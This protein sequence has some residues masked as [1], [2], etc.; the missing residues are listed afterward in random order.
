M[1]VLVG[2]I[3]I[4]GIR[5]IANVT[6]KLVPFMVLLYVF[7]ALVVIAM[8]AAALPAAVSA[9]IDGAFTL[10]GAAG[11]FVGI[12]ILGFQR[13]AFSNE[14]GLGSAAIAH[15]AVM[16]DKPLTEGFVA[17]LEPFIDTVVILYID[18]LGIGDNIPP[19]TL[20]SGGLS[21]I[22]LTSAAFADNISWSPLVLSV[23]ALLFAFSTML[24]WAY[25]GTK[26]WTYVFGSS[27][28]KER[29]FRI[30]LLP[31]HLSLGHRFSSMLF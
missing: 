12:M 11:G 7:G 4:G 27:Q 6:S 24:A 23:V 14:A 13:A 2:L 9:I 26:G 8:N 5:S 18:R 10:Q 3:I 22:E 17:L 28:N 15:S 20:T 16:T 21:G 1:A 29:F 30:Y 31:L 25:Y 19:E